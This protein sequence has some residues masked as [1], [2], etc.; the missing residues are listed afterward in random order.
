MTATAST[1]HAPP[2]G[3]RARPPQNAAGIPSRCPTREGLRKLFV[4]APPGIVLFAGHGRS[5]DGPDAIRYQLVLED[6]SLDATQLHGIAPASLDTGI[7][8]RIGRH[9]IDVERA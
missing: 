1:E 4:E 2:P 8:L 5:S 3:D 6:G 9:N 7:H